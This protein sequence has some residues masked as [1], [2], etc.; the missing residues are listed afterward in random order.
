VNWA[1]ENFA[2]ESRTETEFRSSDYYKNET[3]DE[4]LVYIEGEDSNLK[5]ALKYGWKSTYG[6]FL[7]YNMKNESSRVSHFK[8]YKAE[9][10]VRE[11]R[12]KHFLKISKPGLSMSEKELIMDKW[13]KEN[14][15]DIVSFRGNYKRK[16]EENP[17]GYDYSSRLSQGMANDREILGLDTATN[18][19]TL[20][21]N[22]DPRPKS[23]RTKALFAFIEAYIAKHSAPSSNTPTG[24]PRKDFPATAHPCPPLVP[25]YRPVD[26]MVNPASSEAGRKIDGQRLLETYMKLQEYDKKTKTHK[27][28]ESALFAFCYHVNDKLSRFGHLYPDHI[29]CVS[30]DLY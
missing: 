14:G 21:P 29:I 13:D 24:Q 27:N 15:N 2:A 28:A 30:S 18:A 26:V 17:E 11:R 6:K 1:R 25:L 4:R 9:A 7:I 8:E 23:P 3:R 16:D 5:E 12:A 20:P 19:E 22:P 10:E